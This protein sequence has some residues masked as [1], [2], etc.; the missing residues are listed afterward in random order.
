MPRETLPT[1]VIEYILALKGFV[2]KPLLDVINNSIYSSK[3]LKD[4][5]DATVGE[6]ANM[7]KSIRSAEVAG[8]EEIS[9]GSSV[10]RRSIYNGLNFLVADILK[11]YKE[12]ITP[13]APMPET[14]INF[15]FLYYTSKSKGHYKPHVDDFAAN[16]RAL[17]ILVGLSKKE[18]YEGG[19]LH[20]VDFKTNGIKL[21]EG[22]V[23]AFPSNFM[24]P[25]TVLPVTKGERKVLVIW[26][27]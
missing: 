19:I 25:H 13:F 15:Q 17:T 9:I 10:T 24:Y 6:K 1:Q 4:F 12:K 20:V 26:I 21:D 18:D 16:P 11:L 3:G 5:E 27:R 23:V 8:F 14:E 2:K 22:D 7:D